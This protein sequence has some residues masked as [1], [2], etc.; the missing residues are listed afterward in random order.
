MSTL[1]RNTIPALSMLVI[2]TAVLAMAPPPLPPAPGA[3]TGNAA[4][5]APA[6]VT[7]PAQPQP[8]GANGYRRP[9]RAPDPVP[10]A[11][12][13]VSPTNY[14]GAR[15]QFDSAVYDFGKAISGEQVK[16]T[17]YFTNT[18][19]QDLVLSNVHATCGCTVVG[20]WVRQVKPG[21]SGAIPIVFNTANNNRPV[22]KLIT[23]ICN[24]RTQPGGAFTLQLKGIVWKPV[25]VIPPALAPFIRPDFPFASASAHI[26]NA[27]DQLMMLSP[28][29]C[30]NPRFAAHLATNVLG[31]DYTLIVS[32]SAPL[33]P[34]TVQG[35]VTIKTSLTNPALLSV[36]VW[37]RSQPPVNV[38][39]PRIDLKRAPLA[40]N[41]LAYLTILNNCTNPITLSEPSVDAKDVEVTVTESQ[42]G[43]R[44]TVLLKFPTGFELP[45]GQ[46]AAFTAK[47][48]HPQ[49][50]LVKVPI[51]QAPRQA[52]RPLALRRPAPITAGPATILPQPPLQGARPPPPAPTLN[53]P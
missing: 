27:L 3:A 6:P 52:A 37:A 23:G 42:P 18:G 9:A 45:A 25:D 7:L 20:D 43:R 28:P 46:S 49:L 26:T 16:H 51:Y 8:V 41:Q 35:L 2:G 4:G 22:T 13:A 29:E 53:S 1:I 44:F 15:I 33:P 31:R 30:N 17:F 12:A 5:P 32:N 38:T 19:V 36:T 50:P 39:P 47:T 40:T 48:S 34:G 14:S 10:V 21:E 24:D 11:A